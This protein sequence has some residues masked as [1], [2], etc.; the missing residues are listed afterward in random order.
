MIVTK[1]FLNKNRTPKGGFTKAQLKA[2]GIDTKL[3]VYSIGKHPKWFDLI[4]GKEITKTQKVNFK[5]AK[6]IYV[7]KSG[8]YTK[9]KKMA[10]M[11]I[12]LVEKKQFLDERLEKAMKHDL[13]SEMYEKGLMELYSNNK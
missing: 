7:A 9:W 13:F 8:S 5:N 1:D 3:H 6:T 4:V 2:L 10:L 11:L 12:D